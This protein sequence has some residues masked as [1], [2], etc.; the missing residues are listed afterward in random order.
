M[1][2]FYGRSQVDNSLM[3]SAVQAFGIVSVAI[4]RKAYTS[5]VRFLKYQHEHTFLLARGIP[6]FEKSRQQISSICPIRNKLHPAQKPI[7]ALSR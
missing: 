3:R 1:V 2:S 4:F 6:Q 5:T 7:P